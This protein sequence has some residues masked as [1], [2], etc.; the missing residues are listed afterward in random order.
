MKHPPA[1]PWLL[2]VLTLGVALVP[3][4]LSWRNYRD[5]ARR[6]DAQLFDATSGLAAERLQLITVRHLNFFNVL[7]NQL[8]TQ[9]V[10]ARESLHVPST[11]RE[12]FP[13]LLAFGYAAQEKNRAVLRWLDADHSVP[14][15][16]GTDLGADPQFGAVIERAARSP[17]PVAFNVNRRLLVAVAVGEGEGERPRG[18]AVGWIDVASLCA[19]SMVAQLRD[20]VL[21]AT[22]LAAGAV[23]PPSAK[24]VS[25][26][27]CG[28]EVP[29]AIARGPRFGE[30]YGPVAPTLVFAAGAGCALLLAFLVFQAVRASQ[31]R[32]ALDAERMRARLVQG[33]SHEFRT[34]LSVIVSSADLLSA[35]IGKIEPARRDEALAQIRDSAGRMSAMVDEILLLSRLESGRVEPHL[36]E[37][38][39]GGLCEAVV[40]EVSTAT[41]ERCPISVEASGAAHCDAALLRGILANLL[42]NA[43]KYSAA[44][45][46]VRLVAS[47]RDGILVLAVSDRGIGIPASDLARVGEA[48]HR[49]VNVGDTPGTGLGLAIVR[50]S[51]ELMGAKFSLQSTEGRGT[52]A[53]L[54]LPA[55]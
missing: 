40:R 10:P 51:A 26:H 21:T 5:E 3:V 42:G 28:A 1:R 13:H 37:H 29:V 33:F 19:D 8:R 55:A 36:A 53:T 46:Q 22:P 4:W 47:R 11:L 44:G 17:V 52:T 27:E 49:A 6:K 50:R 2:A 43:V 41:R 34:P 35:Y 23:A 38:D 18:F 31:L 32:A 14:A 15:Q 45:S 54:T 24:L 39:L 48:F 30:T 7:R 9:P 12:S 16:L 20:G 25:I